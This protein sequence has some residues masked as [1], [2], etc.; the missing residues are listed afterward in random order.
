MARAASPETMKMLIE[1][2][3][4]PNEDTRS[5]IVAATVIL[6][7]AFGKPRE[8]DGNGAP[9]LNLAGATEE[10]LRLLLATV[11]AAQKTGEYE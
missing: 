8:Q 11:E 7:R 3:R 5:R 1:I 10:Q 9:P 4:D 6:D 2:M